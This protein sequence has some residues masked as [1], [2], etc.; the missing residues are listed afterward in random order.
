MKKL[1]INPGR[2]TKDNQLQLLRADDPLHSVVRKALRLELDDKGVVVFKTPITVRDH[3]VNLFISNLIPKHI[4]VSN[5]TGAELKSYDEALAYF[6]AIGE[7]V[8]GKNY[9]IDLMKERIRTD[10]SEVFGLKL[11]PYNA[12]RVQ[13]I[14]AALKDVATVEVNEAEEPKK[15]TEPKPDPQEKKEEVNE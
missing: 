5:Y 1:I 4:A 14:K 8:Y 11:R 13:Q 9:L 15:K 12:D 3:H 7:T 2:P 6:N 10:K